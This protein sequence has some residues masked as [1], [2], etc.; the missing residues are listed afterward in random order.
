MGSLR[1]QEHMRD[2]ALFL[3]LHLMLKPQLTARIFESPSPFDQTTGKNK[4]TLLHFVGVLQH[5]VSESQ[6]SQGFVFSNQI[7]GDVVSDHVK[8]GLS[9]VLEGLIV[10]SHRIAPK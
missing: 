5:Y 8:K 6:L 7:L 10:W 2:I 1:A 3:N 9:D 4:C